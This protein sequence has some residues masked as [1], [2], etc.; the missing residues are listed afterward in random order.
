MNYDELDPDEQIALQKQIESHREE[1]LTLDVDE[2]L[3]RLVKMHDSTDVIIEGYNLVTNMN[4]GHGIAVAGLIRLRTALMEPK[5]L[6]G[7]RGDERK[8]TANIIISKDQV[9][10]FTGASNDIGF[11]WNQKENKYDFIVS[12]YDKAKLMDQRIIQAYV[13]VVLEKALKKNGFKIKV[14]INEEDLLK[15]QLSDLEIKARKII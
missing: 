9:N 15:R 3:E 14:N 5:H 2:I 4:E 12:D 11:L 8:E 13:K 1:I 6:T 7:Y 10:K